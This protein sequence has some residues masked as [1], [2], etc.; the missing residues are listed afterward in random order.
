MSRYELY[1]NGLLVDHKIHVASNALH[2]DVV[3]C[4]VVSRL[5]RNAKR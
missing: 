5:E 4:R 2:S 3:T 1:N